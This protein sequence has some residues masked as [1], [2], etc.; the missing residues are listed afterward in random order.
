LIKDKL[1][2]ILDVFS[3]RDVFGRQ[4]DKPDVVSK[5]IR[6]RILFLIRDVLSGKWTPDDAFYAPATIP[7][8]SGSRYTILFNIY[9][10]VRTSPELPTVHRPKMLA[11]S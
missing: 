1:K 6:R 5:S 3:R 11:N 2:A 8:S 10:G 4:H 9:T 7:V